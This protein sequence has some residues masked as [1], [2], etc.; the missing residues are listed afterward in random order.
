[1]YFFKNP[2]LY[3][4]ITYIGIAVFIA[5]TAFDT[6]K[7]KR[8]HEQGFESGE[9]MKKVALM[10]SLILY[11]DFINLFLLLLRVMGRRK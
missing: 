8:I 3:W 2:V 10:G 6:Q 5:L 7:L 11:L 4:V 9:I 1:M